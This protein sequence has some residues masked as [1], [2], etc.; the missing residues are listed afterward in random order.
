MSNPQKLILSWNI[1]P[2]AESEYFE[3]MVTEFIPV[4]R[5]LGIGDPQVWYTAYGDCEQIQ[6]SGITE[7]KEHMGSLLHSEEW[8][9]LRDRLDDLVDD[10]SQRV[11]KAT[12]GFQI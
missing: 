12:G 1:R 6:V 11:I 3:F 8:D 4:I 10:L 9:V 7:T 2:G 5:Q